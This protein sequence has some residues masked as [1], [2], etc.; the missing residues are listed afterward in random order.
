VAGA[1]LLVLGL[2]LPMVNLP[3]GISLSFVDVPFKVLT[4]A[5]GEESAS[6]EHHRPHDDGPH[7]SSSANNSAPLASSGALPVVVLVCSVVAFPFIVGFCALL[8]L[9][10]AF[11]QLG[12][13]RAGCLPVGFFGVVL[14][15]TTAFLMGALA[16]VLAD[17]SLRLL[18]VVTSLGYGWAVLFIGGALLVAAPFV[19]AGRR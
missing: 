8:A 17:P 19:P 11:V 4:A 5:A 16:W 2:F 7:N 9:I 18:L 1:L 14:L 10:L 13:R 12:R 3:L 15:L 6:Y